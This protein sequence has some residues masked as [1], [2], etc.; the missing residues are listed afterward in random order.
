MFNYLKSKILFNLINFLLKKKLSK[1]K[2]YTIFHNI[3]LNFFSYLPYIKLSQLFFLTG[4]DKYTQY[5]FLYDNVLQGLLAKNKVKKI[6]EIGI[7]GHSKD[8]NSGKSLV[9]FSKYYKNA[10]IYGMDLANKSFLN[11]GKIKT[12][13][14]DQGN[15]NS[16]KKLQ[17]IMVF[18]I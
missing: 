12:L 2:Y 16:L 3:I 10:I 11:K 7:G 1:N 13:V 17:K 8:V 4:T 18:S 5:K 6:L 15:S 14:C 9:A